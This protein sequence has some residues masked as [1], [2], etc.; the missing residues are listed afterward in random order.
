MR[1][2]ERI[3]ED[4]VVGFL[5]LDRRA[6]II[7]P[8]SVGRERSKRRHLF[9]PGFHYLREGKTKIYATQL[10]ESPYQE[11]SRVTRIAL[12]RRF[13]QNNTDLDR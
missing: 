8:L 5:R 10:P 4:R 2:R 13:R 6:T 1:K 11:R 9:S 3:G 7:L 12:Y